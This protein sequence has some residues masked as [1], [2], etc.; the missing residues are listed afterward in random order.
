MFDSNLIQND[1]IYQTGRSEKMKSETDAQ[2]PA[3]IT[4]VDSSVVL[5]LTTR[6]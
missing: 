2:H 3:G 5:S 1:L 4:T 6:D